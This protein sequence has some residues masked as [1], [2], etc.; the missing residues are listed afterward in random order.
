MLIERRIYI[1]IVRGRN[2]ILKLLSIEDINGNKVA[3]SMA[4]LAS[5]RGGYLNNLIM[6]VQERLNDYKVWK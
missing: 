6:E 4:V 3:L 5:L 2:N 1:T